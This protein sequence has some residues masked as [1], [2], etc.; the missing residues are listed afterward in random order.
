MN[1]GFQGRHYGV[2]EISHVYGEAAAGEL[3][4]EHHD[5]RFVGLLAHRHHAT[6]RAQIM[7]AGAAR[8]HHQVC[9]GDRGGDHI[10][11]RRRGID[12]DYG[13]TPLAKDGWP[14]VQDLAQL[15]T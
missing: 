13:D 3:R 5:M 12:D 9:H 14:P 1:D 15:D 8:D 6:H 10:E 11:Q 4:I 2:E 7:G